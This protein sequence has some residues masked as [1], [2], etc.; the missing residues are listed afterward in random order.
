MS[1]PKPIFTP[2]PVFD[3]VT[4]FNFSRF[5]LKNPG[6]VFRIFPILL[7][8]FSIHFAHAQNRGM[9][10]DT[11]RLNAYCTRALENAETNRD[12]SI[13]FG[14][15]ALEIAR[16]LNQ[17]FYEASILCDL[18]FAQLS[19][20]DYINALNNLLLASKLVEDKDIGKKILP[21]PYIKMFTK[22]NQPE[23]NRLMLVVYIKNNL[24]LL[25]GKTRNPQKQLEVLQ[26]VRKIVESATN[27]QR[28][29]FTIN[30]N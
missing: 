2:E 27:D 12:K 28:Q 11:I 16:K 21:T 18:G 10:N 14:M 29:L 23:E 30:V 6:L 9:A 25:Y 13:Y 24:A 4:R 22:E 1:I 26:D 7:L 8:T 3:W 20:G 19:N 15:R 17:K 5:K